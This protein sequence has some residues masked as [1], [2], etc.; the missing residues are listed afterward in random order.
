[1]KKVA[2]IITNWNA[3]VLVD[4]ETQSDPAFDATD[5]IAGLTD[6]FPIASHQQKI[7]VLELLARAAYGMVKDDHSLVVDATYQVDNG[8]NSVLDFTVKIWTDQHSGA[9]RI[10]YPTT[11]SG[12]QQY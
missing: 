8:N 4:E 12:N 6:T 9:M 10:S 5:P 2:V 11:Q 7:F 3:V 1:V